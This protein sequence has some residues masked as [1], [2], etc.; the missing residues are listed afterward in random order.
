MK[1]YFTVFLAFIIYFNVFSQAHAA[2]NYNVKTIVYD[3]LEKVIQATTLDRIAEKTMQRR[4]SIPV[5]PYATGSTVAAMVRMGIAG[6]A[7]YGLIEGVG[8]IIDNGV[9]KKRE[10]SSV[11]DPSVEYI[12]VVITVNSS[13]P[14]PKCRVAGNYP[15]TTLAIAHIKSCNELS[16]IKETTCSMTSITAIDCEGI[17]PNTVK[18]DSAGQIIRTK[19]PNYNPNNPPK[20]VPVP[21]PELGEKINNS[22]QAPDI[23]PKVYHPNNPA[24]GPAPDSTADAIDR[25]S[26]T[27]ETEPN[28]ASKPKPNVDTDGDGIPDKYDPTKP[29][30]GEEFTLPAF[31]EWATTMCAWYEKYQEDSKKVDEHREKE[32][33]FWEKVTDWIDWTKEE[34]EKEEEPERPE[35]DDQG[36]FSRTFDTVFSLSKQCPPDV[37]YSFETQYLKGN[38]TISLNWLCMIFTFLGYPLQLIAHLTGLWILYETVVRKEIKW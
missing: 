3:P 38:F 35:I 15:T 30:A 2:K 36:I 20:L 27:P 7:I 14:D 26:P 17:W 32:K 37:P 8:W 12:W 22:P 29:S 18:P 24:G 21:I 28:G 9:V 25:A 13:L 1:K 16:N 33:T 23:L 34:P 10:D 19:N 11:V 31:C 6:A 5:T 4:A